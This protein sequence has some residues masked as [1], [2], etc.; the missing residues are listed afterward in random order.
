MVKMDIMAIPCEE[1]SFDVILCSHV[2]EEVRDDHKAMSELF[3]VLKPGGWAIIQS[4]VDLGRSETLEDPNITS[5][6]ERERVFGHPG[7]V[8]IYGRDYKDRLE[9]AGFTVNVDNYIKQLDAHTIT[10]HSLITNYG[11]AADQSI[12][13]CTKPKQ[14]MSAEK[15]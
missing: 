12:Y 15:H 8:R 11:L 1:N 14:Y 3:R 5:P 9:R 7:V 4:L 13:F 2:L 10:R 6:E